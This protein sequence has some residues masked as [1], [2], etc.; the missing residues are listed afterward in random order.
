MKPMSGIRKLLREQR[1][2]IYFSLFW[3]KL[4]KH[5]TPYDVQGFGEK[6]RLGN[7]GDGGYLI[8]K[9]IFPFVDVLYTYGVEKDISFEKDIITHKDVPV[10]LY[11]HT[12]AR[13]PERNKNFFFKKQGIAS[14]KYGSFDTF[15]NHLEEN[16]D[17]Q[18]KIILKMDIE[19]N[20]WETIGP[21]INKFYSNI[22]MIVLEIHGLDEVGSF[23][24]YIKVL[25]EINSKFAI[26]HIHGNNFG[27]VVQYGNRKNQ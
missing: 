12:I 9:E 6:I 24:K 4:L 23:P 22:N 10:R 19:G 26:V 16:G 25:K 20:E 8:P 7:L 18:K 3:E 13:L 11:D 17:K 15:E 14:R 5:L 1:N 21:I 27:G 2:K